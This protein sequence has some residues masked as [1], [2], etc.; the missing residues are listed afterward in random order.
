MSNCVNYEKLNINLTEDEKD[1][2]EEED[3]YQKLE[4]IAV[5]EGRSIDE[6]VREAIA[7][8]IRTK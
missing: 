2:F 6:L 1:I 8:W 3:L 5:E 7:R 4:E